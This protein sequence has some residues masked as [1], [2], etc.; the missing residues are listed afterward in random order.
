MKERIKTLVLDA[1]GVGWKAVMMDTALQG[2]LGIKDMP[3]LPLSLRQSSYP[4]ARKIASQFGQ[5]YEALSY[6]IDWRDAICNSPELDVEVCNINNLLA[7]LRCCRA[8]SQYELIIILHSAA[9]DS[10]SLLLKM[11]NSFNRRRG[12]I[13]M[14]IG[15]EYSLLAEKIR[16]IRSVEAEYVC[17]QLPLETARW[18][19]ADAVN[20]HI[21]SMPHALN[22]KLY[23]PNRNTQRT[24]DIGFI[25]ALYDRVIG[26]MERTKLIQFFQVHGT[27]LGLV[28]DIRTQNIPRSEWA[29][30]LN[31]CK[32]TVGAESG[33]YYLDRTGHAIA[34]AKAYLK[35][36]PDAIFE[37][38]FERCFMN[39]SNVVSGKTI[40]SRHFEPIGTKTCQVLVEG[41]Y[42]GILLA[43]KHYISIKKDLSN[44]DDAINRF[45]DN[46]YRKTMVERSYEYVT[47]EHTYRKRI[48]TLLKKVVN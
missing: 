25:G 12:K 18:L 34:N 24:I 20:S 42:N 19:Y 6:V 16:F 26:D 4:L 17:S 5:R 13:I 38:I 3:A 32:G 35:A 8:I 44:I 36:H 7:N 31:K 14:F 33:T 9:G 23:Y 37:E 46:E 41:Q 22:P 21:L 15:N 39:C 28:C 29:K 1:N 2:L 11:I 30:F 43:D 47:T 45:K 27:D 40:S 10:M 48:E